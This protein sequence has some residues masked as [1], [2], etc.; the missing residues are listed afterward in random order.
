MRLNGPKIKTRL[1]FTWKMLFDGLFREY[2]VLTIRYA[3]KVAPSIRGEGA[4]DTV[5]FIM[6]YGDILNLTRED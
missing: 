6:K 2:L 4:S 5:I 1:K 3:Y